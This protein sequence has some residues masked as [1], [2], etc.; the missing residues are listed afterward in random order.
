MHGRLG[1]QGDVIKGCATEVRPKKLELVRSI[2]YPHH[3]G[4]QSTLIPP[5]EE[6]L[7]F[8]VNEN[9][10]WVLVVEKEVSFLLF[11]V[12]VSLTEPPAV[13]P[14]HR[15][16]SKLSATWHSRSILTCRERV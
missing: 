11:F 1:D 6:I 8:E 4:M 13:W 7:R 16:F 2:L 15:P 9:L 12:L 3:L 5:L 14:I 10:G